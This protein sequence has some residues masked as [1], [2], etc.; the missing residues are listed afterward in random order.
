MDN[1]HLTLV[2]TL[3]KCCKMKV[4]CTCCNIEVF[5]CLLLLVLINCNTSYDV[6]KEE[7][8]QLEIHVP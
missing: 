1:E 6:K 2:V 7:T 8:F 3:C 4:L 5:F